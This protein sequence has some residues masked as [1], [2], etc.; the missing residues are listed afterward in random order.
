MNTKK[1][2]IILVLKILENNTDSR[3]PKT[4]VEIAN[5]ISR[6]YPCDRKTVGRNIKFLKEMG[7]PIVKTNRGY[8]M[9]GRTF[10]KK[11]IDYILTSVKINPE[12]FN[13]KEDLYEKLREFL[14]SYY[15]R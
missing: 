8:Y 14:L 2:L 11:E 4:Q 9:E 1:H 3:W 12:I 10:N 5:E 6:V 7:Y 15:Q 13:N